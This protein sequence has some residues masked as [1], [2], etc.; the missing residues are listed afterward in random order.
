MI[1]EIVPEKDPTTLQEGDELSVRVLKNGTPY[2]A[3][4]MALFR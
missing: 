3:F 2:G 1:L 4:P